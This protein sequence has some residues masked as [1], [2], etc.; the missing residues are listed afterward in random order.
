VFSQV[1]AWMLAR[2]GCTEAQRIKW[3]ADVV[4]NRTCAWSCLQHFED[5]ICRASPER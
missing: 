4:H 2:R 3:V 5:Q 1:E